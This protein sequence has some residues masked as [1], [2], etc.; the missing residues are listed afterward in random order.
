MTTW[1]GNERRN[2]NRDHDLLLT[3]SNDVKHMVEWTKSHTNLDDERHKDNLLKFDKI[4]NSVGF[5]S[6]VIYG[7]LGIVAFI[8]LIS[9]FIK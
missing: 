6:K 2:G 3:V 9:K 8:D 7:V 4:D 5:H 1:D